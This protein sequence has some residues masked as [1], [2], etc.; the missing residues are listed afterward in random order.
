MPDLLEVAFD[1]PC[2]DL[3]ELLSGCA[4]FVGTPPLLF[5]RSLCT[6][7]QVTLLLSGELSQEVELSLS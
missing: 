1:V 3:A 7:I 2:A 5:R 6:R 4:I